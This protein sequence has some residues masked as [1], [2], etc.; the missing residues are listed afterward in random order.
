MIS[1]WSKQKKMA[2]VS[3]LIWDWPRSVFNLIRVKVLLLLRFFA[4]LPFSFFS[5]EACSS[6]RQ[7]KKRWQR[8]CTRWNL[9]Y[10][11][12]HWLTFKSGS[13][14]KSLYCIFSVGSIIWVYGE[15][16][17]N[18]AAWGVGSA[19][20]F[21]FRKREFSFFFICRLYMHNIIYH[22]IG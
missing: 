19:R 7:N 4:H 1:A 17:R 22:L 11:F 5:P 14:L 16:K 13:I 2:G 6:F 15:R 10:F 18:S 9:Y 12:S 3:S 20:S 8:S 21:F